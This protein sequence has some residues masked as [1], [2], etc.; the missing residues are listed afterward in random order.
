MRTLLTLSLLALA[1]LF[2]TAQSQTEAPFSKTID[3]SSQ[4]LDEARKDLEEI[5]TEIA[6]QQKPQLQELSR[7]QSEVTALRR[8]RNQL[9]FQTDSMKDQVEKRSARVQ[10]IASQQQDVQ[11]RLLH[12]RR[13][14]EENLHPIESPNYRETF[15][16]L[17]QIKDDTP[18]ARLDRLKALF[19]IAE[20]ASDRIDDRI[21]GSRY[22]AKALAESV[23]VNGTALQ[24]GPYV[25]FDPDEGDAGL[26]VVG[27][28]LITRLRQRTPGTSQAITAGL[29]GNDVSLPFDPLLDQAFLN[30]D[31]QTSFSD[32]LR[33]GGIW[34]IPITLFGVLSS[35]IALLKLLQIRAIRI[36]P[37]ELIAS[38][39]DTADPQEFERQL[40]GVTPHARSIFAEGFAF[41][42]APENARSAAMSQAILGFRDRLESRLSLL[43]LTAA[44]APLLGLLGT[45]T[46]MIKTFQIISLH[47]AGDARTLSGGISEALVTTE[48]G[49]VVAI[50]ALLV[51]AW[52]N[53][54]SK[55]ISIQTTALA[56]RFNQT[57]SMKEKAS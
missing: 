32:H 51:H 7:I 29:N 16:S 22:S 53:R 28:D 18:A 49:L 52:L 37:T 15:L 10:A 26:I 19:A 30:A 54:R 47:G 31:A 8:E 34:I 5:R 23:V 40:E 12:I 46:G 14:F 57:V 39:A 2:N 11:Y 48:F 36:P 45:V 38:L 33:S 44:V 41:R 50:P 56:E 17:E 27:E 4:S 42:N 9:K 35:I 24:I 1:A 25:F 3:W 55:R 20:K 6:A 13:K 21:G 43:A